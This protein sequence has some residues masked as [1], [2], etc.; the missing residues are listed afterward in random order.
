MTRT[1]FRFTVIGERLAAFDLAS[2][3]FKDMVAIMKERKVTLDPTMLTFA[4]KLPGGPGRRIPQDEGFIDPPA[5]K[6]GRLTSS[7]D[8]P[9]ALRTTYEA[10]WKKLEQT[11]LLLLHS[12]FKE[13]VHAG[14][15]ASATLTAATWGAAKFLGQEHTLGVIA[16]GHVADLYL[17]DGDPTTDIAAI[18]KGRLVL[19]GDAFFCPDELYEAVNVK[20]FATHITVPGAVCARGDVGLHGCHEPWAHLEGVV[21]DGQRRTGASGGTR[22]R[23]PFFGVKPCFVCSSLRTA[24]AVAAAVNPS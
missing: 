14:I 15:P 4:P 11:L 17:V 5:A 10:S 6:R 24:C 13:W 23:L 3:T 21:L 19:K 20:P 1:L 12:E 8:V 16:R 9:P 2:A 7:L 22:R 18:R